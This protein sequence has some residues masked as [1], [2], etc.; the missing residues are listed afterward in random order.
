VAVFNS[1]KVTDEQ[2]KEDNYYQLAGG[3]AAF[4]PFKYF[5]AVDSIAR[6]YSISPQ[7]AFM[8]SV[9]EAMMILALEKTQT[10]IGYAMG[11]IKTKLEKK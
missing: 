8:F 5:R 4:K 6:R 9:S 7:E 1:V 2:K 10:Y 3:A 11:A